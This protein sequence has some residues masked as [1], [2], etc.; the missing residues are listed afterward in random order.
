MKDDELGETSMPMERNRI[1]GLVLALAVGI[2]SVAGLNATATAQTVN[3]FT[4][5]DGNIHESNIEFIAALGVTKGCNPPTNDLYCPSGTVTRGQMAAFL[6]RALQ[7][8]AATK[9]HFVDDNDSIFEG[10]INRLAESG[11]TAGCNPPDNTNFCPN[12]NVT[13]GQMAAFLNR[14]FPLPTSTVD[15]FTDDDDS[16]FE[17]DINSLAGSGI[18]FGCGA[19]VYCPNDTVKRDQMA[20]FLARASD[21]V[22][23]HDTTTT[24]TTSTT[25]NDYDDD[26]NYYD[27]AHISSRDA[28]GVRDLCGRAEASAALGGRNRHREQW[29]RGGFDT[30]F[31]VRLGVANTGTGAATVRPKLQY[32]FIDLSASFR[33]WVDVTSVS[34]DIQA[35][36]SASLTDGEATTER[37]S[38]ALGFVAGA[39]DEAD[40]AIAV[41]SVLDPNEETEFVFSVKIVNAAKNNQYEL[42]LVDAGAGTLYDAYDRDAAVNLPF[43]WTNG[44]EN[45][46]DG[47]S[48]RG[49][50]PWRR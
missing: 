28:N 46:V 13:R 4:D 2:A 16:I 33:P 10:D 3:T 7:L 18:T 27:R 23:N 30:P 11:I 15:F 12:G 36:G 14:A 31:A 48:H 17:G 32:R 1:L 21:Q 45:G 49:N 43:T 5:D 37:L 39:V 29:C 19:L 26:H 20:S 44:F 34:A 24:T 42:R 40:G 47:V 9:D 38:G 50:G 22:S 25:T 41:G 8:P 35:V 6:V